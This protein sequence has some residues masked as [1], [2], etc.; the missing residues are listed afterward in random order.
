MTLLKN[1]QMQKITSKSTNRTL[2]GTNAD[3]TTVLLS[4][5]KNNYVF[6]VE[7]CC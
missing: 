6:I 4:H 2:H 5:L 7:Y 1:I 3:K